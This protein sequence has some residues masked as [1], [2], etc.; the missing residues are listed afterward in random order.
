MA[1]NYASPHLQ[2]DTDI[3]RT[4][5]TQD[6]NAIRYINTA[7]YD[8]DRHDCP[9]SYDTPIDPVTLKPDT[10]YRVYERTAIEHWIHT[11][12]TNPYTQEPLVLDDLIAA[13]TWA[14]MKIDFLSLITVSPTLLAELFELQTLPQNGILY[15]Y[16]YDGAHKKKVPYPLEDAITRHLIRIHAAPFRSF[17]TPA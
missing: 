3:V 14:D 12:G 8:I 17:L 11:S 15:H 2:A 4:A 6:I 13:T 9:I 1:L 10:V 16:I 7:F 5:I